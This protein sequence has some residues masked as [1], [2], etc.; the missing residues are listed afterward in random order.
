MGL[1]LEWDDTNMYVYQPD[2]SRFLTEDTEEA[3]CLG[4]RMDTVD[5]S[6]YL[7]MLNGYG[8][9]Y[10]YAFF[11]ITKSESVYKIIENMQFD[12]WYSG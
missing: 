7:I 2:Y 1:V 11:E 10:K 6:M 12:G 5:K 9:D 4:T 8:Y 3:L